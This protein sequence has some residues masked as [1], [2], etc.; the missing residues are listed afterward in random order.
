MD[1]TVYV[2]GAGASHGDTLRF[3]A[4][5]KGDSAEAPPN[6]PLTNQFF[7]KDYLIDTPEEV[8]RDYSLLVTHIRNHWGIEKPLGKA[9]WASLSI[10]EVFTS[11]AT[12]SDFSPAGTS[13]KA[14][15][16]IRLNVLLRY[17]RR[18]LAHSCLFRFGVYTRVLAQSLRPE[19]SV[20]SFNYDL[21]MDQEL[22]GEGGPL[23]YQNFSAK[24]L[25]KDLF[26]VGKGYR[27]VREWLAE[28][29]AAGSISGPTGPYYGL[30]LKLHGSLNWFVCPSGA[31]PR[32]KQLVVVS[33]IEQCLGSSAIG[34][35]FQ[36]SYCYSELIPFLVPPLVQKPVMNDPQLRNIWGNALAVLANA[37]RVVVI[38]FSFQPSDFYAAWLFRRALERRKDIRI[39]VV[40]PL[41]KKQRF[42][43]RM[44]SIFVNGYDDS[45]QTFDQVHEA[46][47][48]L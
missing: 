43:E 40:N 8:E 25:G 2:L 7:H 35:N 10:E 38:G 27:P 1:G 39:S 36:C 28:S 37:A 23:Q 17:I 29:V 11:I 24:M 41:N 5:Y 12:E 18:R 26:K 33:S 9:P 31:C 34:I 48:R 3:H 46:I 42:G 19:D 16:Q 22:I 14:R 4:G 30:Y 20:L 32:S 45:L 6:P 13:E 47:K 15:A 44:R 21:L